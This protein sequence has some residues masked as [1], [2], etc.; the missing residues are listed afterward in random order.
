MRNKS[1]RK[2]RNLAFSK[3][4]AEIGLNAQPELC[5]LSSENV[6]GCGGREAERSDAG[7]C[8]LS[9]T[10]RFDFGFKF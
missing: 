8:V 4:G 1:N 2:I 3:E 9:E 10:F 5:P 7:F 6:W